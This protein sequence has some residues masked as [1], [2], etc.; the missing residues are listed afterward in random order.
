ME[1]EEHTAIL[2]KL[3]TGLGDFKQ[4]LEYHKKHLSIAKEVGDRDGEGRA[5]CNLGKACDRSRRF[6]ASL[7]VLQETS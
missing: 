3:V 7:R 4:A 6:Q 1:R 5:Y 2:A